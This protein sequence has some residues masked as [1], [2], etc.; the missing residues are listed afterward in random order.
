MEDNNK[1][2]S[3][4]IPVHN[5]EKYLHKSIDSV[6]NQ[7]HKN[8]EVILID[9]GSTDLSS[10][11][12]KDYKEKDS[13]I[14]YIYS[15]N[16][17]AASA[18]N[19]GLSF[20][21][22]SF[23]AFADSDDTRDL[24]MLETL[25]HSIISNNSDIACCGRYDQYD[26]CIKMGLCPRKNVCLSNFDTLNK[27]FVYDEIDFSPC[28][29]L[30]KAELWKDV[31]FPAGYIT[32][33]VMALYYVFKKAKSVS[34]VPKPMLYYFHHGNS[35]T[36]TI[37]TGHVFDFEF[38]AQ[39]IL[40]DVKDNEFIELYQNSSLFYVKSLIYSLSFS[41]K[42][43]K[44]TFFLHKNHFKECIIILRKYYK[45]LTFRQKIIY[46]ICLF[47]LSRVCY[48]LRFRNIK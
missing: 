2:I 1:L 44:K 48:Y 47:R 3:V 9:D 29:K 16:M 46:Y 22:G 33:D 42:F 19:I 24:K 10:E 12:C 39:K 15:K 18:R 41:A 17:G 35:V 7:T 13:R 11:I 25:L 6:L 38:F 37:N 34:F 36:S 45:L 30:F 8:L 14:T 32:E 26:S 23:V 4:I 21:H 28:D 31:S 40:K 5:S 27:A 20:M 43:D